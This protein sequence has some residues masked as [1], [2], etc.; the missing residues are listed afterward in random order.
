M[1]YIRSVAFHHEAPWIVSASDDQTVRIWNW[2]SRQCVAVL[3][4][5][6]HYVMCAAFHPTEDLLVSASLDQTVRVWDLTNIRAKNAPSVINSTR[7][8]S[9]SQVNSNSPQ[10]DLFAGSGLDTSVKFILEGH[11]RGVNWVQFHPTRP[12]IVSGS[13]DRTVKIWR[14]N[15]V[16][17]WEIET[18]RGHTNNVSAVLWHPRAEFIISDS[19]DRNLRIWDSSGSTGASSSST[20]FSSRGKCTLSIKKDNDRFWC[21]AAHPEMNIF[22]AGH[23][24]GLIVF[25][26]NR[27]RP[28]YT[29]TPDAASSG[30]CLYYVRDKLIR[31]FALDAGTDSDEFVAPL[32]HV[33]KLPSTLTFSPTER[34]ILISSADSTGTAIQLRDKNSFAF[35]GLFA[36]FVGRNR[37][38][39]LTDSQILLQST[40]GNHNEIK[41]LPSPVENV[42]RLLPG[43]LGTFLAVS[44]QTVFLI[45]GTSGRVIS[46]IDAPGVKYAS[47]S[48]NFDHV[49]LMSKRTIYLSDKTFKSINAT[50]S[51]STGVKSGCWDLS[52]PLGAIF[53]Y[54][55]SFH[56]K[57]LLPQGDSGII[58]STS[59]PLYLVRVQG[60]LVHVLDRGVSVLVLGIDPTECHFKLALQK[61]NSAQIEH[62]IANSNLV[63]QAIIAYLRE[64]GHAAIALQFVKDPNSRFD[65]ALECSNLQVAWEA[66][67]AINSPAV[68][69]KL[70]DE[71]LQMGKT[72]LALKAFSLANNSSKLNFLSTVLAVNFSENQD[73][74]Q[75]IMN[76][77]VNQI[78]KLFSEAGFDA[79]AHLA[80]SGRSAVTCDNPQLG[81]FLMRR[82]L[83]SGP[84][85]SEVVD[86]PLLF[87]PSIKVTAITE[88]SHAKTSQ[89]AS[90]PCDDGWGIEG[91]FI[92]A[93]EEATTIEAFGD[94]LDIPLDEDDLALLGD[95]GAL[96][97]EF[98]DLELPNALPENISISA[99]FSVKRFSQEVILQNGLVKM[100]PEMMEAVEKIVAAQSFYLP[101]PFGV[102]TLPVPDSFNSLNF[103]EEAQLPLALQ[104]T[105]QGRFPD[106]LSHFRRFLQLSAVSPIQCDPKDLIMARDYIIGLMIETRRKEL[107]ETGDKALALDLAVLFTR[108]PLKPEH[109]LLSLRAALASAYKFSAFKTAAH[110]ARRLLSLPA[111]S[112]PDAVILQARKVLAVAEKANYSE[113][114][115]GVKY[116]AFADDQP[117][118]VDP[119][120]FMRLDEDGFECQYCHAKYG[121]S[122]D[123]CPVCEIGLVQ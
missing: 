104:A 106:A 99:D 79:L 17:A 116:G 112:A 2:Q 91:D 100:S 82:S 9:F 59:T 43:P 54:T 55:N 33:L 35:T 107:G 24:N 103:G 72:E 6:N 61:G 51:D 22:A 10:I 80:S 49:A 83:V 48:P 13:D 86:W 87:D 95:A 45:D 5:H 52:N 96:A 8:G 29:L 38:V 123:C 110:I 19:E 62:L 27:E 101:G 105:T 78:T 58:C 42:Q 1:D 60:D 115:E 57:Y 90:A 4:G 108:C 47:W 53:Y 121:N 102:R 7:K 36:T 94:D 77:N 25:K 39:T 64:K 18:L 16:R 74:F 69:N 30:D 40:T 31:S 97:G 44:P 56:L 12:F 122:H 26:M 89:V 81:N 46:S 117:W 68:W 109:H 66:A 73:I 11:D 118:N 21:L 85:N 98:F 41:K 92:I 75:S 32:D 93:E 34:V 76:G 88:K 67:E 20:S 65:L 23:D 119:V 37:F 70:A 14:Y 71:A 120:D 50:H 15:D 113:A 3:S 63:G 111:G 114:V 84:V 28:S